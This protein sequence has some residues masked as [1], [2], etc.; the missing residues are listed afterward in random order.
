MNKSFIIF[1]RLKVKRPH[2]KI[3]SGVN[4]VGMNRKLFV[5]GL[6]T[7]GLA[8]STG[9]W[10]QAPVVSVGGAQEAVKPLMPASPPASRRSL[11]SAS[12]NMQVPAE[13]SICYT[14]GGDWPIYSGT[15]PTASGAA[16]RG[17]AC[18]GSIAS[19]TDTIPY[20]CSR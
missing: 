20:L 6:L 10:A 15:L 3:T 11:T 7:F 4:E 1:E 17:S 8:A 16:E 12:A 19:S 5:A 14:C 18:A 9:A 13:A 2:N